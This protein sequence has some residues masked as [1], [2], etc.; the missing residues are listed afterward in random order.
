MALH[1][2][3]FRYSPGLVDLE[4]SLYSIF[5]VCDLLVLGIFQARQREVRFKWSIF[6]RLAVLIRPALFEILHAFCHDIE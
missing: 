5:K 2:E 4:P 1:H 6:G 3:K